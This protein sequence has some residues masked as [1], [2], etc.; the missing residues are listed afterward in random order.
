MFTNDRKYLGFVQD[1]PLALK[2]VSSNFYF[3]IN[4]ARQYIQ[5]R[6]DV[7]VTPTYMLFAGQDVITDNQRGLKF[8]ERI[9]AKPNLM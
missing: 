4:R 2:Q 3:E 6:R 1:D 8:L 7:L 9:P 5:R